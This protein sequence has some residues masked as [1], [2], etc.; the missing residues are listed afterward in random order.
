MTPPVGVNVLIVHGHGA[1]DG[2]IHTIFRGVMHFTVSFVPASLM[3]WVFPVNSTGLPNWML[4]P[5]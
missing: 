1:R 4:E 2:P 5:D 3:M